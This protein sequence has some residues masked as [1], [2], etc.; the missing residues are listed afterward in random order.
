MWNELGV[1]AGGAE[2]EGGGKEV[3]GQVLQASFSWLVVFLY[4]DVCSGEGGGCEQRSQTAQNQSS[5]PFLVVIPS[6]DL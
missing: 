5:T 1:G 2:G 4:Q 3:P 6:H